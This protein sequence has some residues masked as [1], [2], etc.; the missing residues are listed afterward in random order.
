VTLCGGLRRGEEVRVVPRRQVSE[1]VLRFDGRSPQASRTRPG[2]G[3]S[4]PP[5]KRALPAPL[6]SKD[7]H[8]QQL[9]AVEADP[10]KAAEWRAM[11]ASGWGFDPE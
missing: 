6:A 9:A 3:T 10:E 1:L 5:A 8:L 4:R 2:F 7:V 11:W